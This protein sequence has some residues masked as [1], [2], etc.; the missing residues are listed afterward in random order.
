[1]L[2]R[3]ERPRDIPEIR[4]LLTEVFHRPDSPDDPVPEAALV[5]ALRDTSDWIPQQSL[6]ALVDDQ[7][8]GHCLCTRAH[9]RETPVLGLGPI[10]V[11][12]DAQRQGIGTALM[13]EAI[14]I[15]IDMGEPLIG[16][17]GDYRYYRRFG[18]VPSSEL[19]IESP[20]PAW[21][22]YF[23]VRVLPAYQRTITGRFEYA[24]L[25]QRI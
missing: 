13:N 12:V 21:G 15:A 5:D 19:G 1:M 16:L 24:T 14:G 7:L 6:V 4:A 25:F 8:V 17:L 2:I 3:A 18:F 11:K 23:Q 22:N 10:G 9:V 20:E